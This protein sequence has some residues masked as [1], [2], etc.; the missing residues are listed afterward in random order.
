[1][2]GKSNWEVLSLTRFLL[3]LIVMI[4]H[5]QAYAA[6]GYLKWYGNL[7]AFEA[8]LGF[9]LIS[10]FSIGKSISKNKKNYFKRRIQRIYP[11]Y[12]ASIFFQIIVVWNI[13]IVQSLFIILL[14]L[15]FLNHILTDTSFVGPAWTLAA[16]VWLYSFAPLFLKLNK[17][18]LYTLIFLS[19]SCYVI[20]TCGRTLFHWNY[21]SRTNCGINLI[22]LAFI[23]VAGFAL[24]IFPN[25]K[26]HTSIVV[27]LLFFGHL[28]LTIGIQ[29]LFRIKNH[30]IGEI[31]NTDAAYFIGNSCCLAFVYFVVIFNH[32]IPS[33]K[34]FTNKVL[35]LLGNISYPLYLTHRTTFHLLSKAK[36]N[37]VM[38]LI[39]SALIISTII[40][41][42]FDFYSKKRIIS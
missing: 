22:L 32:K 14:N 42:I 19:F 18:A 28:A 40:Y 4:E 12:L 31:I 36:I 3:A 21:Y 26:K 11:V 39:L 5:L 35:N 2:I 13:E 30:Q 7:G 24:A 17:K 10:G 8:I 41:F 38:V 25:D 6:I 23:W 1:M 27:A 15:L 16:E 29:I 33:F 34:P 37:N 20:Y 9:L